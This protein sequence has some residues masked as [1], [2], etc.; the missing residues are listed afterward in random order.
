MRQLSR[1]AHRWR[2]RWACFCLTALVAAITHVQAAV[3][4]EPVVSF[5]PRPGALTIRLDDVDVANYVYADEKV[6]RPYFVHVKT[7]SGNQV[8]R[9]HPAQRV[10][11]PWITRACIR[12]S[13]YRSAM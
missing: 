7:K 11:M 4:A 1:A 13:G 5:V 6:P 8:T 3:A 9:Q 10:R 12:G 2:T